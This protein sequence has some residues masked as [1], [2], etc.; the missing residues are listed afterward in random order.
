MKEV[1]DNS[2]EE[3]DVSHSLGVMDENMKKFTTDLD[4]MNQKINEL[5]N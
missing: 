5:T 2:R 4:V 1:D 3:D